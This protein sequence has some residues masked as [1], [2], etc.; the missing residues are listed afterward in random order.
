MLY[1]TRPLLVLILSAQ[2]GFSQSELVFDAGKDSELPDIV[3]IGTHGP[4]ASVEMYDNKLRITTGSGIYSARAAIALPPEGS[5]PAKSRAIKLDFDP[6]AGRS[7]EGGTAGL[8]AGFV[9]SPTGS[10]LVNSVGGNW[11]GVVV[12]IRETRDGLYSAALRE[13]WEVGDRELPYL[14]PGVSSD[15]GFFNL[16]TLTECPTGIEMEVEDD[17]VRISFSGAEIQQVAPGITSNWEENGVEK[18][19]QPEIAQ[20]LQGDLDA[21]FGLANYG[22]L[23]KTPVLL[24][25]R[26]SVKQ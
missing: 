21:A 26:F 24:L 7:D 2:V 17:T 3:E 22:E 4:E 20:I 23:M 5:A 6:F 12:E 11:L 18:S 1:I 16:C 19:L 13:R 9:S 10:Q 25:N 15:S 8:W 14:E